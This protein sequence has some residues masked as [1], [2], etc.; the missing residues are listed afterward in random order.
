MT[1]YTPQLNMQHFRNSLVH[2]AQHIIIC[3]IKISKTLFEALGDK[4][5]EAMRAEMNAL[6]RTTL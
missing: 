2:K 1:S 4:N 6:K 5:L 3:T